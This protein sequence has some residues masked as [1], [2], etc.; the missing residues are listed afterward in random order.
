MGLLYFVVIATA[1]FA[2]EIAMADCKCDCRATTGSKLLGIYD[3]V[4]DM[5]ACEEKCV[6]WGMRINSCSKQT[7]MDM[8]DE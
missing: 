4:A 1:A 2:T 3:P 8:S 5:D 6:R 7:A